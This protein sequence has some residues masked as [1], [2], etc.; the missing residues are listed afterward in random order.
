M[1]AVLLLQ[2]QQKVVLTQMPQKTT[3]H[4]KQAETL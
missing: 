3:G 2:H 4:M 1:L